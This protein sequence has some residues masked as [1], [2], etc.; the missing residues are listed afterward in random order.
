MI[1]GTFITSNH[2]LQDIITQ[3][4]QTSQ[5]QKSFDSKYLI[6]QLLQTDDAVELFCK[7]NSIAYT[8]KLSMVIE[9]YNFL[10]TRIDNGSKPVTTQSQVRSHGITPIFPS[11]SSG[12]VD[13]KAEV[14]Q[15][16]EEIEFDEDEDDFF[17]D[18]TP[19]EK[20]NTSVEA[21]KMSWTEVFD[22]QMNASTSKIAP[23]KNP[24]ENLD[25]SEILA[26]Q[27][28]TV[29]ESDES[30]SEI[31]TYDVSDDLKTDLNLFNCSKCHKTLDEPPVSFY[32]CYILLGIGQGIYF[33]RKMKMFLQDNPFTEQLSRA[34]KFQIAYCTKINS[35]SASTSTI[36]DIN[37]G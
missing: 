29:N 31:V 15:V 35:L 3:G 19:S 28:K 32:P 30:Q 23:D 18:N 14:E 27:L 17:T 10:Q 6:V 22:D 16:I 37:P 4:Q 34:E 25:V 9:A 36:H 13:I 12:N 20:N 21:E 24:D 8:S 2:H 26:L 5:G 11:T 1:R 33:R 7:Q